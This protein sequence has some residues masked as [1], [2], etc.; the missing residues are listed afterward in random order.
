VDNL[1]EVA[2]GNSTY[3]R[4]GFYNVRT[5]GSLNYAYRY[6]DPATW[7]FTTTVNF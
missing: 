1:Y 5:D 2:N 7:N 3:R 4:T 6:V